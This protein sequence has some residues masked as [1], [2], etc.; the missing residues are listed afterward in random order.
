MPFSHFT[1]RLIVMPAAR[2]R[3]TERLQP[4]RA[5]AKVAAIGSR[6]TVRT[7]YHDTTSADTA[8]WTRHSGSHGCHQMVSTATERSICRRT[9]DCSVAVESDQHTVTHRRNTLTV[10]C[11]DNVSKLSTSCLHSPTYRHTQAAREKEHSFDVQ[12]NLG[13][14]VC[15]RELGRKKGT[16]THQTTS[17]PC[18]VRSVWRS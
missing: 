18:C 6:Q 5:H 2:I 4:P 13:N 11:H 9:R 3:V 10:N 14:A 8:L 12:Q 15:L 1:A 17:S 16:C 7:S